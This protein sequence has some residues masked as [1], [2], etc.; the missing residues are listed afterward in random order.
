[1]HDKDTT[2]SIEIRPGW[3]KLHRRLLDWEW[4]EDQNTKAVFLHCL[5]KANV[6]DKTWKGE[7]INR[8]QFI[9]STQCLAKE[10]HLSLKAVR[11]AINKLKWG[12]EIDTFGASHWT[13]ITVCKYDT[14][15]SQ[16]QEEG[17]A[18]LDNRGKQG[19]SKGQQLK[20]NKNQKEEIPISFSIEIP[21]VKSTKKPLQKE[22]A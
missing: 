5:L 9:T 16:K 6:A 12:Q 20:N 14:Y 8:G 2:N 19:A 22:G 10:V 4:Y 13:K 21:S 15:Q 17:Q 3:I 11:V 7:E 1:M 18:K